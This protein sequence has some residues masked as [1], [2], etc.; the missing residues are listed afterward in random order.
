MCKCLYRGLHTVTSE[1]LPLK[2]LLFLFINTSSDAD[3]SLICCQSIASGSE[4]NSVAI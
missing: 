4:E 2:S 1:N 3:Y